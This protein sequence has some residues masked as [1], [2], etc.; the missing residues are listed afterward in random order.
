M[1]PFRPLAIAVAM[2]LASQAVVAQQPSDPEEA[3]RLEAITV[4]GTNLKGID[5][6]EAQ[7]VI[8]FSAEDISQLGVQSVAELLRQ[9]SQLGGGTGNFSEANSGSKQGDTPAGFS[10][11]SLRGLGTAS[12]LTLVNGRRVAVASFASGSENF[13]DI[14]AIPL[15]A[16]DRVDVLTT[17]ASAIYGADAVAGVVNFILR[18]DFDGLRLSASAADSS[19]A[20]DESRFNA[21]LIMGGSRGGL[22]GMLI[23]DAYERNAL[24]DR[25][26]SITAVEP[27]PSQQGLYPSFNDLFAMDRDLVE[28]SCPDAQRFD[29][30][31]GFPTA[32]FGAYCSL[33]RNAYTVS[34]PE[35]RR[36]GLYATGA[37]EFGGGNE[38]FT[39]LA[40]QRNTSSALSEPAPWS[41][42]AIDFNHPNMPSELR[43]RL[44]AA[45]ADP[46]FEI[47][48]WG[49]F[50]DP[51]AIEVE[52]SSWRWVNGLSGF[53]G[54]WTWESALTL[55]R[56]ESSQVG[57]AG[58]YN[59][60]RFR[61]ALMGELCAD[62]SIGCSPGGNGL[63]YDP[64]SG[65]TSNTAQVLDL[66]RERV[67]RDGISKLYAWD[68]KLN[69]TFGELAGGDVA[70]AFGTELRR[71]DISDDPSPLATADLM[72]GEVPVYGFG[73]TSVRAK[74]SQWAVFAETFLPLSA[75]FDVRLAGRYDHYDDFGGDFNPSL[76]LRWRAS[77]S[78]LVR[79]GWNT[80]FRA[81]SLAQ[82]GAG[83]T[84]SSGA[85]PCSP[86]SEFFQ[87]FCDG[88][89]GDD[90]YLSEIYGNPDLK[91]ESSTAWYFGTVIE[92]GERTEL[93]L[94]YWNFSHRNLV[95]V[96]AFELFR[97]ALTDPS[98]V[99]DS[100]GPRPPPGQIGIGT[101]GG[102]IG[103]PVDD[104]YLNLINIGQQRTDG[105]DLSLTHTAFSSDS[106]EVRLYFDTTWTN[107]F[108]RLE[109]CGD[110]IDNGRR[111]VGACRNGTRMVERV[112]EFRYPEWLSN[113][114]INWS[115]GDFNTRIWANYTDGYYDDDQRAGVPAGRRV[116]SWTI[117]NLNLGWDIDTRQY[118]SLGV[119]NLLD[120]DPPVALG[121]A[122]NVDLFN[123]DALGRFVTLSYVYRY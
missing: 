119:R 21:N 86:G 98:L 44:L 60:E 37:Y 18:R 15:A 92:L 95:G 7:P 87:N 59:V 46:D 45:G 105:I 30:R 54:N 40:V 35:T 20:T 29:G 113:V 111:G 50:P 1:N 79:G 120:R 63:Y 24:Y 85:L 88:F 4:T 122:A 106:S 110:D 17:G 51:R 94:D 48:G 77:Q 114:G 83:T 103:D 96:D 100:N 31:P 11:V 74:R 25:D 82:V 38:Y 3:E 8:S 116:A 121:S 16:V 76:G 66:L 108:S 5:L 78:W 56:S 104:I 47:F 34:L 69:G 68:A 22:R 89:S 99:F 65:Q 93:S 70:W 107:S 28:Q 84:L 118:L 12:T 42:E 61:A 9:I 32:S 49:R 14:N 117:L 2:A 73:S 64:F 55:S 57:V 102:N 33:N 27:R 53:I 19:R 75:T 109:S 72:T 62:G 36:L 71:E 101:R 123:H 81:P 52:S 115:Y 112:G 6:E 80:A 58:I 67:P 39:E 97:L 10:G 43:A 90:G 41:G 23:L 26:R 91:A 13:V